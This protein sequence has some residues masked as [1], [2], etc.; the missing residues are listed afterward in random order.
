M[1]IYEI[2]CGLDT[3]LRINYTTESPTEIVQSHT[4]SYYQ[5]R[6]MLEK[7]LHQTMGLDEL[8]HQENLK[9]FLK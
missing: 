6:Q 7:D 4:L 9:E 1:K 2:R 8:I 3:I 5:V